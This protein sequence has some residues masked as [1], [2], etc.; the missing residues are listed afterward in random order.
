M[1]VVG[2]GREGEGEGGGGWMHLRPAVHSIQGAAVRGYELR[3]QGRSDAM[4]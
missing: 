4:W 1:C 3:G 2:G